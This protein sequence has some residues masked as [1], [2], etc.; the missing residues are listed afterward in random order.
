MD[1]LASPLAKS[2][3]PAFSCNVGELIE[4]F[5]PQCRLK[6]VQRTPRMAAACYD[7]TRG[8]STPHDRPWDGY[9]PLGMTSVQATPAITASVAATI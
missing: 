5:L 4:E 8:P 9:A 3:D 2:K 1:S 7:Q 6:S